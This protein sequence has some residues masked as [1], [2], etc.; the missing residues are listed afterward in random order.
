[1]IWLLSHLVNSPGNRIFLETC[2]RRSVAATLINPLKHFWDFDKQSGNIKEV[3]PSLIFARLG[4]SAP[5]NSQHLLEFLHQNDIPTFN[6][7]EAIRNSRDKAK[8]Y[9]LLR[10]VNLPFPKS[11]YFTHLEGLSEI[12]SQLGPPP[13]IFKRSDRLPGLRCFQN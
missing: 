2:D 13:W 3:S 4:S 1:M 12:S 7:P 10:K 9:Q 8:T 6:S 5:A 11:F